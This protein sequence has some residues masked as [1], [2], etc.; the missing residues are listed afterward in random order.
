MIKNTLFFLAE[1]DEDDRML[2]SEAL[3][4][5]N[6]A[7]KCVMAK[8]GEEALFLLKGGL[9][10]LPDFIFLDLNMPVM[11]GLKCLAEIKKTS[12]LQNIPVVIYSTSS[13][14]EFIEESLALG[15]SNFF[16]KP[17]DFTGLINY[18]KNILA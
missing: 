5:I 10:E 3:I 16:V 14:K 9:F 12:F 7:I 6:P 17:P 11:N 8:N 1:D 4:E 18:L 15:A 2:F 13:S